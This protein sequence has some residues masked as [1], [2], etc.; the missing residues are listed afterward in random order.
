MSQDILPSGY[1]AFL[2]DVKTRVQQA[3]LQALVAV[4]KELI[5]LYWH[6]GRGILE[7]QEKQGWGT[8]VIEQLSH[9]LHVAFPQMKGFSLRN[10]AYMKMFA[11]TYPDELFL[12]QV[13]ANLPWGHNIVLLEK[14]KDETERFWYMQ[15]SIQHGWS[16][17]VLSVQIDTRLYQRQ[18]KAITNFQSTLP[19]L[20]SD[21]AHD[22]LKDPYISVSRICQPALCLPLSSWIYSQRMRT[23]VFV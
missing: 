14:I 8:G 15:K 10:L 4:N 18:G 19:A 2:H 7:R 6:I 12:Q 9:D 1:D 17:N 5:L 3:Q 22:V 21:F 20:Q 11:K 16:R 13:V 23:R